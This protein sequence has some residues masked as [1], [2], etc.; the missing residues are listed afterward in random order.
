MNSDLLIVTS[1]YNEDLSWLIQQD[2]FDYKIYSKN[3]N[4][5]SQLPLDKTFFC[6]NKGFEASSYLQFIIDYYN[7]L[8]NYVAFIHGHK[9]S[10]HQVDDTLNLIKKSPLCD[11]VSINRK[12]FKNFLE[13][14]SPNEVQKKNWFLVYDNYKNLNLNLPTPKKLECTACAQFIVSKNAIHKNNKNFYE[15][16]LIWLEK[17]ELECSLSG[18]ILEHLWCYIFTH[19][20]IEKDC[21]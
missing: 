13:P 11:Y 16:I 12:D 18:R 3:K 6:I 4:N 14:N 10:Y 8:P 2:L 17:T 21:L 15:N 9:N 7:E 5:T 19:N 20:E 1:H